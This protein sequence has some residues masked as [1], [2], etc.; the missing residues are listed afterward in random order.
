M[1][2]YIVITRPENELAA[3]KEQLEAMGYTVFN[4]PTIA[5]SRKISPVQFIERVGNLSAYDWILF[6]SKNGVQYFIETI[7][8]LHIDHKVLAKIQIAAVGPKTAQAVI[9]YKLPVQFTPHRFTT[10]DLAKEMPDVTGKKILLP[11]S[12][13]ATPL[14]TRQ[15]Q[16]RGAF[17]VNVPIYKTTYSARHSKRFAA[18]VQ[19]GQV[20]YIS[21]TSPSTVTGLMQSLK[22][23]L[24]SEVLQLPVLSIGPVT[25]KALKQAGFKKVYTADIQTSEGMLKKLQENIL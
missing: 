6:T 8:A 18:L 9:S 12:D 23:E 21:F 19:Q 4:Y 15:L 5:I 11:R 16:D 7:D 10:E 25:T 20:G 2:K 24:K 17:V 1:K 22:P 13:I 3:F 14:L